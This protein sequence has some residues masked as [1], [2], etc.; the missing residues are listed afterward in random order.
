MSCFIPETTVKS[1]DDVGVPPANE[2]TTENQLNSIAELSKWKKF[3]LYENVTEDNLQMYHNISCRPITKRAEDDMELVSDIVTWGERYLH[4]WEEG[5]YCCSRCLT[6]LYSSLAKYRGPCIWPS[7]REPITPLNVSTQTVFPY[8][9]YTVTVK[10]V[11][12]GGCDLFI[13]HQFEDA[14]A[15]GDVH[16]EAHWRH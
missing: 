2:A 10:E 11:Y 6:P 5:I 7:F 9:K 16:P 15:K 1:S 14:K 12:C 13:G 3:A 4:H 8:N